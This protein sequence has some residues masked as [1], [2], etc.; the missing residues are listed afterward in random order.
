MRRKSPWGRGGASWAASG[1]DVFAKNA[2]PT[3][4]PRQDADQDYPQ[5]CP[6]AQVVRVRSG[7]ALRRGRTARNR[8][9]HSPSSERSAEVL[10]MWPPATGIRHAESAS[11]RVHSDLGNRGVFHVRDAPGRMP[12][13][14]RRRR[15][16]AVGERQASCDD[17]VRVVPRR[18]G[19][20]DELVGGG[21]GVPDLLGPRVSLS[22][23][24]RDVGSGAS[25]PRGRGGD[26][27]RGAPRPPMSRGGGSGLSRDPTCSFSI[28]S[29][30]S[31]TSAR[32]STR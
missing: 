8:C 28:T 31:T 17:D 4:R 14:W 18:L 25:R 15:G 1:D 7:S 10:G 12:E 6:Q 27:G 9:G 32:R 19:E 20:E 5:P 23:D 13:L 26:R 16:G 22:R 11:V 30:R 24:G 2:S 3:D 29:T 21:G